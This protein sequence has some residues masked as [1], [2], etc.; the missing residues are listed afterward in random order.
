M[1]TKQLG[2]I[3]FMLLLEILAI[4]LFYKAN[5]YGSRAFLMFGL[6]TYTTIGFFLFKIIQIDQNVIVTNNTWQML[7]V[8]L[9]T[10]IGVVYYKCKLSTLQIVGVFLALASVITYSCD[11]MIK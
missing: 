5:K 6:L 4:H 3:F 10:V 2:I 7:N 8:I 11:D 9:I 1:K